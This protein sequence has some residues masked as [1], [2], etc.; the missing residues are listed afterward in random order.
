VLPSTTKP[1]GLLEESGITPGAKAEALNIII[2][3]HCKDPVIIQK[4]NCG[5]FRHGSYIKTGKQLNPHLF[6]STCE[7]LF[8]NNMIYGCG[9][10]F[11]IV[12][13]NDILIAIECEYI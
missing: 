6:Q 11:K 8:K 1:F 4:I 12:Q 5:I 10:P 9:K 3:P 13:K 2:C 7:Y